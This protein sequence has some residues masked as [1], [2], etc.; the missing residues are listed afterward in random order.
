MPP[1]DLKSQIYTGAVSLYGMKPFREEVFEGSLSLPLVLDT[2]Q[3]SQLIIRLEALVQPIGSVVTRATM[4]GQPLFD[5]RLPPKDGRI[6]YAVW[7]APS[8]TATF[9]V[10]VSNDPCPGYF[11]WIPGGE[12][13]EWWP[14]GRALLVVYGS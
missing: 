12:V 13:P 1:A 11:W 5:G 4:N 10:S 7:P 9:V 2:G 8:P 14:P 3:Y 6:L